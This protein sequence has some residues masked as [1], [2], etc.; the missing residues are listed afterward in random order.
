MS[1]YPDGEDEAGADAALRDI[2]EDLRKSGRRPY[3]I[4]LGADGQPIGAL[5]YVRAAVEV[6]SLIRATGE[7]DEIIVASGSALT[8]A[9]L[10]RG[11]R[12]LGCMEQGTVAAIERTAGA[13][14]F[15]LIQSILARQWRA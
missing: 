12:L 6:N 10:S 4:P 13:G 5:G 2:A 7:A 14:G 11:L 15:S 3:V 8:H 9:G 1:S